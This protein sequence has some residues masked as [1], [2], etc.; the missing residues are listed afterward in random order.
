[1]TKKAGKS[2]VKWC[3]P[4]ITLDIYL[5]SVLSRPDLVDLDKGL[6]RLFVHCGVARLQSSHLN[7][8][9]R[10]LYVETFVQL[11]YSKPNKNV[12]KER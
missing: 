11:E 6:G 7:E 3:F 12:V 4:N 2:F 9:I 5:R 8:N 1:M 10:E